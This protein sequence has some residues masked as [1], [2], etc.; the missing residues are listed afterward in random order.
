MFAVSES[1]SHPSGTLPSGSA[2][3]PRDL[4]AL[5]ST[6]IATADE[7]ALTRVYVGSTTVCKFLG[8][9]P[10]TLKRMHQLRMGPPRTRIGRSYR[11]R[12]SSLL[13]WLEEREE[14]AVRN[15]KRV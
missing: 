3:Q 15:T 8:I 1:Q 12:A 2:D 13:S 6:G 4:A 11:Y 10:R 7:R 9:S 14:R 5:I